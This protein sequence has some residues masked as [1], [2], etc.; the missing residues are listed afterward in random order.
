MLGP[1]P[2]PPR[3]CEGSSSNNTTDHSRDQNHR[4]FKAS[5]IFGHQLARK[6]EGHTRILL[7]NTTSIG[8]CTT[9]RSKETKKME[10][11]RRVVIN[12][13]VD[14]LG[15]TELNKRWNVIDDEHTIW[16]A[17]RKWRRTGRTYTAYNRH[18]VGSSPTLYGGTSLSLFDDIALRKLEHGEDPR[19]LGRWTWVSINGKQHHRTL[20]ISAYCPCSNPGGGPE[21]V[22]A[23]H[24]DKMTEIK[25]ELPE[26]IDNPRKLFW[27]DLADFLKQAHTSGHK[28]ILMGDFNSEATD[29]TEW[30]TQHGLVD[31]ICELHGYDTA[32]A[33]NTTSKDAP[34]DAI[35][36]SPHLQGFKG[37]YLPFRSLGGT[38]RG[39][40]LDIPNELLFGFNPPTPP[41]AQARRLQ[42]E[43]PRIVKKYT[44]HLHSTLSST[45]F[46]SRMNALHSSATFPPSPSF[47]NEYEACD[48]LL[49]QAMDDA[50]RKCR[51]FKCGQTDW[52][53]EYQKIHD[54]IDYWML[55]K[56]QKLGK[57]PNAQLLQ[58]LGKRLCIKYTSLTLKGLNEKLSNAHKARSAFK[59]QAT[60]ASM[61]YRNRLAKAKEEDGNLTAAQYLRKLNTTEATRKLFYN[62]RAIE[63]KLRAGATTQVQV[64]KPTGEVRMYTD[65]EDI[66]KEICN[67]NEAK[68][69]QTEG[70][71]QLLQQ[72]FI[73]KLGLHGEGCEANDVLQ[74]TFNFPPSTTQA[75]REFL[76]ACKKPQTMTDILA[77]PNPVA[78]FKAFV[79]SWNIRKERTSSYNQHI[80]HYKACLKHPFLSWCL[81]LRHEIPARTGYSPI[82]HRRCIDLSILKRSRNFNI[83]K[84]RTLGILDSEFNQANKG[85]GY[86]AMRNALSHNCVATEQY[87]RPGRAAID[88]A[89][90]RTLTFDHFLY[91]RKPFCLASCDLKGCYDR[92]V[93]T[94]ASIALQRV[95]VH[96]NKLRSMFSSIQ[97][98]THKIRTAFGDSD[99]TYGGEDI[100]E[101]WQ[102]YPQGVLQGN[103][104]GPQIWSILS[105][106]IFD[107]LHKRGFGVHFCNCLS[108]S[109]FTLLGFSYVDDCDL[110]QSQDDP[111]STLASMQEVIN[112]W[113]ELM[114]VTGG[115]VAASKSWWYYV[116]Y[117]WK[118]R[119]WVATDVPDNAFLHLQTGDNRTQLQRLKCST[120]SEMLGIW[121]APDGS[122]SKM[123]AH[124]RSETL[125]W[126]DKIKTG[127]PS[128]TVAWTALHQTISAKMKYCLPV[129]KFSKEDCDYIMAPAIAI[130]LQRSGIA[131]NFPRSARH[132]PI[133]SGG[134]SVLKL[135][136]E[137]GTARLTTMVEHCFNSTPTGDFIKL[138]IEHMVLET[139]MYGSLWQL[140]FKHYSKWTTP[141]TWIHHNC[142][143]LHDNKINMYLPHTNLGPQ[144]TN[145]KAIMDIA[146]R[147]STNKDILTAL[148]RVRMIHEI[149]H[150]SDITTAD[151]KHL[152]PAFL[153]SDPFP[154]Q[155]NS[156]AW[157]VK[158]K[159]QPGDYTTW[160]LFLEFVFSNSNL[161]L[162]S[163]LGPWI[164][165][166][167]P[168]DLTSWHWFL[169]SN[170]QVLYERVNNSFVSHARSRY[171]RQEFAY[172][173]IPIPAL[174][175]DALP[176]SVDLLPQS[177]RLLNT[178]RQL[179]PP[180]QAPEHPNIPFTR[181]SLCQYLR[182]ELPSWNSQRLRSSPTLLRLREALIDGS[183]RIVSDGSYYH[184]NGDA[185]AGWIIS[186]QNC[187]EFICGG[188]AVPGDPTEGDSYRSEVTGLIGGS[189]ALAAL[190]QHLPNHATTYVVGCDNIA[191]SD[192]LHK[193][194]YTLKAKW[195]HSDLTSLLIDIW[196]SMPAAPIPT[197]IKGHQDDHYGP[198]TALETM[199]I[200]MD[201]L[202]KACARSFHPIPNPGNK[203]RSRGFGQVFL[204]KSLVEGKL[205]SALYTALCHQDYTSY[206]E[207]KWLL[208]STTLRHVHWKSFGR[209][210]KAAPHNIRV[211]ISK[212]LVG[213]LPT[214]ARMTARKH[215]LRSNCPHC[216]RH[217]DAM[218]L[219]T[220][221]SS[222]VRQF[223]EATIE[224]LRGWL[225]DQHTD[226][227]IT[228]FLGD[229]IESWLQDP[230]GCETSLSSF[231]VHHRCSFLQ[232]LSLGWFG[233]ISGMF[234]PSLLNLQ[235]QYYNSQQLQRSGAAWGKKL[236]MYLWQ[237]LHSLWTLRNHHLHNNPTQQVNGEELL[238]FSI[239][240]EYHTGPIGL[241]RL[242]QAYF[243][244]PLDTLLQKSTSYKKKWFRLIRKAREIMNLPINQDAFTTNVILRN[245]VHLPTN[246]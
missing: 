74:G 217:E 113:S 31:G 174:P 141:T 196:R 45:N 211:F 131:K 57:R 103:A 135:Y 151:G 160:R 10:K 49:Q 119:K 95:G 139:G 6:R 11:L 108:K 158:H 58:R 222:T 7:H 43:D 168:S 94:A 236:T 167:L 245:W 62:I 54:Q 150:L 73:A 137:M 214:G 179:R 201:K 102:N 184:N 136:Y 203:W 84:Q 3:R 208:P 242:Y 169:S 2:K 224:R 161:S 142:R 17:L 109:L 200:H 129:C 127:N 126:A 20:L 70:G 199:N 34:I 27:Y 123:L 181:H 128:H 88:H 98:M 40:W 61:E 183:A 134:L 24:V 117:T 144:R 87:S 185:G 159:L 232:Q 148:N 78:R 115:E 35:Y 71:S 152:D 190:L 204:N 38:H 149:I 66:E 154:E 60:S 100:G 96:P 55:R 106:I 164:K 209:A 207:D 4:G 76:T 125:K 171:H 18:A 79:H 59:V 244:L 32:P 22:W 15:L 241:P 91:T 13:E 14:I 194:H 138:N 118:G 114:E 85:I 227:D 30:M 29:V 39:L 21:T 107:I 86:E 225:A 25:N 23:Q 162:H 101:E 182:K 145:D 166:S 81:F 80:G 116:D 50:E 33:T 8:F 220:C 187:E 133:E 72:D 36:A 143:F 147:Y 218:H 47:I 216:G 51:K 173:P 237:Q 132:A 41:M 188:G 178:S 65:K 97:R 176:A 180:T 191:A 238:D 130:G 235:Q 26:E 68:Y 90:N 53:P 189:A 246:T 240:V 52:S 192:L 63:Q 231:D 206:L 77:D 155:R 198:H 67:V 219:L 19:A 213:Q 243:L 205:K 44:D 140:P 64:T 212:W 195:N 233:T 48:I 120:A 82:R 5:G 37:G 99:I 221:P 157:P 69:H 186:T 210:R 156:F 56:K 239:Q 197:H 165:P 172:H 83:D 226:P 234:H 230:H 93:H 163:P 89:L 46:Y 215:R 121:M 124:L 28:V 170:K 110:L 228:T 104:C 229:G 12:N 105:S 75:T 92:I 122:Q 193:L 16:T 1:F 202:A 223:W 153:R 112:G 42:L 111:A 9:E 146:L 177:I 175:P